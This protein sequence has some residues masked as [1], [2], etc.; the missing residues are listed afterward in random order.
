MDCVNWGERKKIGPQST[1]RTNDIKEI[2]PKKQQLSETK[3]NT[4]EIP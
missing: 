1:G 2:E 3:H 4:G